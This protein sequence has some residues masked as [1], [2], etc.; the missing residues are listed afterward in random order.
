MK[1]N[2]LIRDARDMAS[3]STCWLNLPALE[4]QHG[5]QAVAA[6]LG[7]W[8]RCRAIDK[9]AAVLFG[10]AD[11]RHKTKGGARGEVSASDIEEAF[12][13]FRYAYGEGWLVPAERRIA[14]VNAWFVEEATQSQRALFDSLRADPATLEPEEGQLAALLVHFALLVDRLARLPTRD[15]LRAAYYAKRK[16]VLSASERQAFKRSLKALGLEELPE[17]P[18]AEPLPEDEGKDP[19]D[20]LTGGA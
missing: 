12:L 7:G 16:Q 2:P 14:E 9:R 1:E 13:R 6:F 17:G 10:H 18:L 8:Q 3:G 20:V 5:P 19:Y 11:N 4:S 15:E